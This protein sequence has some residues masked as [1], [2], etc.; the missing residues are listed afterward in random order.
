MVSSFVPVNSPSPVFALSRRII[1]PDC[2]PPILYPPFC[3]SSR[4]YL[5]PTFVVVATIPLAFANLKKPRLVITVTTQVLLFSVPSAFINFEKIA[6]NL[7]P[8]ISSPFSSTARHL[9]ASPSKARPIS[10]LFSTTA[11]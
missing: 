7:S 2:S 1:C 10:H 4:T 5:S 8:S 6:S 11:F 3:I 9:S